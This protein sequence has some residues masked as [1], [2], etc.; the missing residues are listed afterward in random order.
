MKQYPILISGKY[1]LIFSL[2]FGLFS[3]SSKNLMQDSAGTF[4]EYRVEI[5]EVVT[6]QERSERLLKTSFEI[7]SKF[8]KIRQRMDAR[9]QAFRELNA[10]YSTTREE[11]RAALDQILE[12]QKSNQA[13]LRDYY[14]EI[15]TILTDEEWASL[16][17]SN[18]KAMEAAIATFK[19]AKRGD[20]L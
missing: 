7:E 15:Q 18:A 12:E 16:R 14:L 11:L 19:D 6:D 13:L 3:C 2:S 17:G 9:N 8:D 1:L 20:W 10:D 5:V 4:S